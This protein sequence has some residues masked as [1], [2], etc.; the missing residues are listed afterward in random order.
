M[1][2][3]LLLVGLYGMAG[4]GIHV[5][6]F[7]A[8][9]ASAGLNYWLSRIWIFGPSQRRVGTEAVLFALVVAAS[10]GL[11]HA[12]LLGLHKVMGMDYRP[13]KGIAIV[14][15]TGFNYVAKRVVVFGGRTAG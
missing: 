1:A 11:N 7:L 15:V 13:S 4:V 2:E 10:F 3:Y 14:I 8:L 6:N 12:L 5:S 9:G